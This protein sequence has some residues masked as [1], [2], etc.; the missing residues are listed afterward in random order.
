MRVRQSLCNLS[1][2]PSTFFAVVIFEIG[3]RVH[4]AGLA[5]TVILLSRLPE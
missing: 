1:H 2:A 5:W 3:S 4:M